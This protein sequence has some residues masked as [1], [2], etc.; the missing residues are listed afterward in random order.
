MSALE[1]LQA[2]EANVVAMVAKHKTEMVD[3]EAKL[4]AAVAAVADAV[5]AVDVQKAVD[6][7]NAAVAS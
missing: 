6:G 5:P 7:I 3:L 1:N 2:A 4:A